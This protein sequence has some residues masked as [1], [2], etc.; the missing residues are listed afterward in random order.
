MKTIGWP[1]T[2]NILLTT[3]RH[4]VKK[5]SNHKYK[6]GDNTIIMII[7]VIYI[8]PYL[9]DKVST[10]R[11]TKSTNIYTLKSEN[12]NYTVIMLHFKTQCSQQQTGLGQK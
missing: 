8:A 6:S 3:K 1:L 12:D 5:S 10:P 2:L 9:T 11:F 4:S 7:A